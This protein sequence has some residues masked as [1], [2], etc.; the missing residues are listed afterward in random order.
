MDSKDK[1]KKRGHFRGESFGD[2][3]P[4]ENTLSKKDIY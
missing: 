3:V 4:L 2:S 1:A